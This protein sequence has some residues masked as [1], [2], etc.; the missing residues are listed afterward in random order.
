[1]ND[2]DQKIEDLTLREVGYRILDGVQDGFEVVEFS[3][4][5]GD[6]PRRWVKRHWFDTNGKILRSEVWERSEYISPCG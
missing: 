3:S 2:F 5:D 6:E 4:E 1:M